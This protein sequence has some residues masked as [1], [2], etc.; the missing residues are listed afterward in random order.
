MPVT[1]NAA[2]RKAISRRVVKIPNERNA[3]LQA[4]TN[5][6]QAASDFAAVD[7]GNLQYYN[8][9][10]GIVSNYETERQNINGY[11]SGT[12]NETDI[13]NSAARSTGN[14][15]FPTVP[16]AALADINNFLN[17]KIIPQVNGNSSPALP[18][19]YPCETLL[20]S[21]PASASSPSGNG[22]S[23]ISTIIQSGFSDGGGATTLSGAYTIGSTTVT[24]TATIGAVPGNRILVQNGSN[25]FI[26]V[27]LAVSG[28]GLNL[29]I[30]PI[31][32]PSSSM[33]SGAVSRAFSGFT[34]PER[35]TLV[36]ATPALQDILN[37]L[38]TTGSNSLLGLVNSWRTALTNEQTAITANE[39]NRPTQ[40]GQNSTAFTQVNNT[41]TNTGLWLAL[42]NT[43]V[44]GKFD[45]GS[46]TTLVGYTATRNAFFATRI[47]QI[48]AD[49]GSVVDN[50][51]G[52]FTFGT[53][54]TD[55]YYQRYKLLNVRINRAYGSLTRSVKLG[56][57]N[58]ILGEL[59]SN[60]NYLENTYH[61]APS[62]SSNRMIA[63]K[64]TKDSDGTNIIQ[65][66]SIA[67]FA[68]GDTVY[69][70]SETM[71]EISGV[72]ISYV[73]QNIMTLNINVPLGY[74]KSDL[75]RI[76]KVTAIP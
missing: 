1:F 75:A 36:A 71:P 49:L 62:A 32:N 29:T 14:L 70:I 16:P 73:A 42:S 53:S 19:A 47:P 9:Y 60:D 37:G 56:S 43:G 67:D 48:A 61:N 65:V 13:Q 50:G 15:F 6:T 58:S 59:I 20:I 7:H 4:Q 3:F 38:S 46:L 40:I 51:D 22:I 25:S 35:Q 63:T 33:P 74:N 34:Q 68:S 11:Q 23:E 12:F 44:G 39:E 28:L 66:E 45:N 26:A 10:A 72:G 55:M 5:A 64:F 21:N 17:P 54:D 69:I 18:T 52:T 30:Y 27:V 31:T 57:S 8:F 76:Y 41:L 2:D 24:L